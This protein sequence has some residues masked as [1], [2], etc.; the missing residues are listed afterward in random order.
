MVFDSFRHQ[1]V[2]VG[3][4]QS[5]YP[6]A[7]WGWDGAQW[8]M[9]ALDGV[10]KRY[11]AG[12]AFDSDR[13]RMVMF[14]GMGDSSTAHGGPY[15]DTWEWDGTAW[16]LESLTGPA[17]R[18][19]TCMAYDSRRHVT[20]LFGGQGEFGDSGEFG[21]FGTTWEWNGNSWA[22]VNG[23]G[24]R[25]RGYH[26]CTFDNRRGVFVIAGGRWNDDYTEFLSDTWEWDG[27]TWTFRGRS[28]LAARSGTMLAYDENRETVIMQGGKGLGEKYVHTLSDIV[29][30]NGVE[31]K[32]IPA[33][34]IE[35]ASHSMVYD[36]TR[37][38]MVLIGGENT[39]W[40]VFELTSVADAADA[41]SDCDADLLDFAAFQSC[42]GAEIAATECQPFDV[43]QSGMIGAADLAELL[44]SF[45]GPGE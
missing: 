15:G 31:W 7:T 28:P 19:A 13:G 6:N 11:L 41:D 22:L 38:R 35:H 29:E 40:S 20:V 17:P 32:L 12:A 4:Y 30:W 26:M 33:P 37:K 42:V 23:E 18:L 24:P 3:G 14:G 44:Y 8:R 36:S 9:L 34:P 10:P 2:F 45:S 1:T 21:F 25:A 43:D 27:Q 16:T 5:L 39:E